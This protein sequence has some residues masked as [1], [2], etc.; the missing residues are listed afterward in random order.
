VGGW[1][2]YEQIW[3]PAKKGDLGEGR[4]T[5]AHK[6]QADMPYAFNPI[7]T[8]PFSGTKRSIANTDY[9]S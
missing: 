6:P 2:S 3:L 9:Q 8:I 1:A 7:E 5:R 4:N